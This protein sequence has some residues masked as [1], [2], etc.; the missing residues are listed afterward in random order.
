[1]VV[2]GRWTKEAEV[3]SPLKQLV[4]RA[5]RRLRLGRA[6]H[7][8]AVAATWTFVA[9]AI[10]ALVIEIGWSLR[11]GMLAILAVALIFPLAAFL[12]CLW[13]AHGV[14]RSAKALDKGSSLFDRIGTALAFEDLGGGLID[15]QRADALERAGAVVPARAIPLRAWRHLRAPL[16]ACAVLALVLVACLRLDLHPV[17]TTPV[18]EV[19]E[20]GEDLLAHLQEIEEQALLRGDKRLVQS[21]TD[22]RDQVQAIVDEERRRSEDLGEEEEPETTT[23]E[24]TPPPPLEVPTPE[25]SVYTVAELE[26]LHDQLQMD[27]AAVMDFD[28]DNA[29]RAARE[30]MHGSDDPF[31]PLGNR[32]NNQTMPELSMQERANMQ[33][34]GYDE[35]FGASHNP[36]HNQDNAMSPDVMKGQLDEFMASKRDEKTPESMVADDRRHALA[37]SFRNFCD[38]YVAERGE[39]MADWLAGNRARGPKIK[40]AAEDA[41]EDKSDAMAK[42]GFEDVTEQEQAGDDGTLGPGGPRRQVDEAP[43]GAEIQLQDQPGKGPA[44]GIPG[45]EGGDGQTTRGAQGAGSGDG[46]GAERETAQELPRQGGLQLEQILGNVTD[47]RLSPE[48]RREILD[49][50]A[51]HKIGGGFAND[52]EDHRGNYFEE[53]ERLLIEETEELPP[54]F[55]QYAHEYF[56]AILEL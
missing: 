18:T 25:S 4:Q 21:V 20:A 43:E 23:P 35:I 17:P 39:Q 6:L 42:L 36:L 46:A 56:Q 15:A 1:M 12:R 54:L 34:G 26:A 28:L 19:E 51:N 38:E 40:V 29:R 33:D 49:E 9:M 8:G 47:D 11:P 41:V 13:I 24:E 52:F 37:E 44:E 22:L 3:L 10:A 2:W 50:V 32:V 16:V 27:L 7:D 48:R 55:R 30:A 53:A 45:G 14:V 5:E 31:K